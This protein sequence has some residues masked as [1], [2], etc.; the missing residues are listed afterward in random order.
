MVKPGQMSVFITE[1]PTSRKDLSSRV[2]LFSS[3]Q[4]NTPVLA[5]PT[6]ATLSFQ[7]VLPGFFRTSCK[8][9][10]SL[11]YFLFLCRLLVCAFTYKRLVLLQVSHGIKTPLRLAV[12]GVPT[13]SPTSVQ[14]LFSSLFS[15][16]SLLEVGLN[17]PV[18][19]GSWVQ[20][21]VWRQMAGAT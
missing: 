7:R 8:Y 11:K 10:T 2:L 9:K 18:C 12:L 6:S 15:L 19:R 17:W 21:S 1:I 13:S 3:L 20:P 5:I 14:P 4:E 16:P